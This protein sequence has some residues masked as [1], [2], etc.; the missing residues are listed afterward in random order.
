MKCIVERLRYRA[1]RMGPYAAWPG[2][3]DP[4]D[5]EAA[6]EIE[7]LRIKVKEHALRR[8]Y[9]GIKMAHDRLMNSTGSDG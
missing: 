9:S 2:A 5:E 8:G 4:L 3:F 7:R 1:R 6:D